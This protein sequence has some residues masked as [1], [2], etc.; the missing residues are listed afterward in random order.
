MTVQVCSRYKLLQEMLLSQQVSFQL[1]GFLSQASLGINAKGRFQQCPNV[2]C[3]SLTSL[4]GKFM[5]LSR[6]AYAMYYVAESKYSSWL[7]FSTT[8]ICVCVLKKAI[9]E[10]L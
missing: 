5:L 6:V 10:E 9:L 4:C 3:S 1:K 7:Y 2:T 8:E